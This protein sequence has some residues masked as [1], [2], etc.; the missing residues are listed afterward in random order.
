VNP[1]E[2]LQLN[3]KKFFD[4]YEEWHMKSPIRESGVKELDIATDENLD[5]YYKER[6]SN[7]LGRFV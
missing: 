2:H 5:I 7:L 1:C 4:T 3:S 6:P